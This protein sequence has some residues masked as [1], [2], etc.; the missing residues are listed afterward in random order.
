VSLETKVGDA[1]D[2][3]AARS[4]AGAVAPAE[5][6]VDNECLQRDHAGAAE[7]LPELQRDVLKMR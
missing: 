5:E 3:R 2:T 6:N 1:E 7:Q 4:A